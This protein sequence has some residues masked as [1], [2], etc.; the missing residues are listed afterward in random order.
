MIENDAPLFGR[1]MTAMVT[2]FDDSG[3]IDFKSV[4]KIVDHLISTGTTTILVSG[5]TGE[6]PTLSDDEKSQLLKSVIAKVDGRV[7]VVMGTGSN[8][9]EKS[10]RAS[11]A[12]EKLGADGLLIVAPY[13]NKPSQAGIEA[14]VAKI[15]SSTTV[16]IIV[17]NIPGR[18]GINIAADTMLRIAEKNSTV[19]AVKESSGDVD[20][21][22]E[23]ARRGKGDFR[24]YSGDDNLTL[25]FLS[26]GACGVVSVVSHVAGS[27]I[28]QMME[29]YFAGDING[30]RSL[31]G[32]YLPLFK[33]LFRAPNPTC[34]KYALSTMGLCKENL[35]LPLIPLD[36]SQKAELDAVLSDLGIKGEASVASK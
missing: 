24:I 33:G 14:H 6:S 22:A 8:D 13:Y 21:V 12:A 9:T 18:T 11:Q 7:K 4:E 26:V 5:T 19:H 36:K 29:K 2:P 25:P 34:V 1:L 3:K 31:H 16:P 17:Y 32:K 23:I 35:R 30:A 15:A 20:Q 10:V 28:A 27:Q